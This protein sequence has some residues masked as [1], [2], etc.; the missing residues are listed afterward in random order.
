VGQ[1]PALS[2]LVDDLRVQLGT[3]TAE[4]DKLRAAA[5]EAS[6]TRATQPPQ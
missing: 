5:R 3:V 2:K 1:D 4:R 6:D